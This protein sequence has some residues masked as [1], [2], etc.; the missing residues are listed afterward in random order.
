MAGEVR[1][2]V[3]VGLGV[4]LKKSSNGDGGGRQVGFVG[5]GDGVAPELTG[6]LICFF[7]FILFL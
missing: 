5:V 2:V 7:V 6:S 1:E 3:D 4:E